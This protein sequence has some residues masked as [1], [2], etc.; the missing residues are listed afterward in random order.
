M[1]NEQPDVYRFFH[2]LISL[3]GYR[4]KYGHA[5]QQCKEWK[6]IKKPDT[7]KIFH[8]MNNLQRLYTCKKYFNMD[9]ADVIGQECDNHK[10]SDKDSLT[11]MG[12]LK[13]WTMEGL[14]Y[15]TFR[16][17]FDVSWLNLL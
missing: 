16:N 3:D 8:Y 7:Q 9:L 10:E 17:K 11:D 14:L 12:L 4:V 2:D 6:C 15:L 5:L 1:E 13:G